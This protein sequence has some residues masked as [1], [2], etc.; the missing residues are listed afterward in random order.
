MILVE[1]VPR[2]LETLYSDVSYLKHHIPAVDGINIPDIPRLEFRS[3]EVARSVQSSYLTVPHIRLVDHSLQMLEDIVSSLIDT[4]IMHAL[5]VSGDAPISSSQNIYHH[6]VPDVIYQLKC[7]FPMF[8]FYAAFDPYRQSLDK[9]F[10]YAEQKIQAGVD[11]IFS[12]PFFDL[13]L[14]KTALEYFHSRTHFFVGVS[15]ITSEKSMR[16]WQNVNNV[17]F[18]PDFRYDQT[19]NIAFAKDMVSLATTFNQS[20]Y[21]MPIKME[22]KTYFPLIFK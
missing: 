5:L 20:I 8:H 6:V 4:N 2:C 18:P 3:Y 11:G 12:Q 1:L 13:N 7:R 10:A 14:A 15:P 17:I 9:E 16:Y 21:F 19:S 22:L